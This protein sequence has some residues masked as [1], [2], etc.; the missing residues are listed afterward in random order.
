MSTDKET[1]ATATPIL[2]HWKMREVLKRYPQL[3]ETLVEIDPKFAALRNPVMRRVQGQLVT[4]AQAARVAGLEPATLVTMLNHAV[5]VVD[6][7]PAEPAPEPTPPPTASTWPDDAPIA[8]ELDVRP[9]QA[10]GEEPF[11]AIMAAVAQVPVGQVLRLL[12]TFEPLPLYEVLAKR[13]FIARST[14]RG[15]DDWEILFLNSGQPG[16][17]PDPVNTSTVTPPAE[18]T[19]EPLDWQAA[20][21]SVT[22]DVSELVPPEPLVKIMEAL[23]ALPPGESLLVHHVRRPMH[24]YPR[25]DELGYR[26][27]TREISAGQIEVLIHKPIGAGEASA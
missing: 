26:H 7:N 8:V 13:G 22:I 3:L 21:A 23:V 12:N 16:S 24:L 6:T 19:D 5:G 10:R 20:T 1:Q 15:A 27:E 9:Y 4:V 17:V 18:R 25:L 14:Q 2:A 11:S